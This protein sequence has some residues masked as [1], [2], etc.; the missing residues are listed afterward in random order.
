MNKAFWKS[1]ET[2]FV[3]ACLV[4]SALAVAF[5][6]ALVAEP[7][8]LFGRSLTAITPSLFPSIVLVALLILSLILLASHFSAPPKNGAAGGI[9]G[10]KRGAIF[11]GIM[12][13]YALLMVPIGFYTSSALTLAVLSWFIGNRSIPQ[14]LL[15]AL[16]APLLLYLSATR[17]LAVSLPELN[18]IELG[19][20]RMLGG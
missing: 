10:W 9:V 13:A 4:F 7:K 14:I 3:L 5:L 1:A 12:T 20:S 8:V 17:L 15:L 19:I 2:L 11:F 18:V 6:G 16:L